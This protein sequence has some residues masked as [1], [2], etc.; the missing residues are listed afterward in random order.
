MGNMSRLMDLL[1]RLRLVD[2]FPGRVEAL[3]GGRLKASIVRDGVAERVIVPVRDRVARV[4][5]ASGSVT[6]AVEGQ[7]PLAWSAP[8]ASKAQ[9]WAAL[10]EREL[11]LAEG[12]RR[13]AWLRL[14]LWLVMGALL[15]VALSAAYVMVRGTPVSAAELP[16]AVP[17]S[18]ALAPPAGTPQDLR[19]L[20]AAVPGMSPAPGAGDEAECEDTVMPAPDGL[21]A[22]PAPTS[23]A[24]SSPDP[25]KAAK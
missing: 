9:R 21:V 6:L 22:G 7:E 11:G 20:M 12:R 10:L 24:T 14:L 5:V 18:P 13:P 25:S 1:E 15:W 17:E 3:P 19:E 4:M 8:D 23:P 2:R 16:P